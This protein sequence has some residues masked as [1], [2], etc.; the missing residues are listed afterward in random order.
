V[1]RRSRVDGQGNMKHKCIIKGCER[2]GVYLRSAA[3]GAFCARHLGAMRPR[4]YLNRRTGEWYYPGSGSPHE[5]RKAG[6]PRAWREA[7]N[8]KGWRPDA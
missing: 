5:G 4:F 1:R 8:A 3:E 2:K 6:K 7:R